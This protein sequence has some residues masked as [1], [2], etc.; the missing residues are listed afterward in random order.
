MCR[1]ETPS[2]TI[3]VTGVLHY[4]AHPIAATLH[5]P[6][7][8]RHVLLLVLISLLLFLFHVGQ[9]TW[10]NWCWEWL[11]CTMWKLVSASTHNLTVLPYVWTDS[12]LPVAHALFQQGEKWAASFSCCASLS[13]VC[14]RKTGNSI[15]MQAFWTEPCCTV[16]PICQVLFWTMKVRTFYARTK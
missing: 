3:V 10:D 4:H 1:W 13:L 6:L 14:Y 7:L 12:K 15:P 16:A 9:L 5:F 8:I 11:Y 2:T